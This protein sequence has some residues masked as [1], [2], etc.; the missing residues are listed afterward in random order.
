MKISVIMA[1]FNEEKNIEKC[2]NSV[3]S[4]ADEIVIID[5]GSEDKTV[6]LAKKFDAIIEI[7]NNPPIFHINKQKALNKSSGNWILQLD[8]DE[9]VTEDLK[10]EILKTIDSK[11]TNL[12]QNKEKNGFYIPRKNFFLG[13]WMK[14]GGLYPDEVIRLVKRGKASFPCKS[15]HEQIEINGKLGHL[16]NPLIHNTNQTIKDYWIN[17]IDRY[18]SLTASEI[19]KQNSNNSLK[20]FFEYCIEKPL[21]TL[22]LRLVRHKGIIDG[23]PGIVFAFGSSIHYPIAYIKYLRLINNNQK[24]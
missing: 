17:S 11:Y 19:K 24:K 2:L 10:K 9:V 23:F 5:G 20:L 1:T 13:H 18:S 8:A 14:K 16:T 7:T 21:E 4:F 12:K 22:Y 15:V 3:K 6:E